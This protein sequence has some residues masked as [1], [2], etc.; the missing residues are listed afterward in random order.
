MCFILHWFFQYKSNV[1][2]ELKKEHQG[3]FNRVRRDNSGKRV[4]TED[5]GSDTDTGDG[6]RRGSSEGQEE[7]NSEK[8]VKEKK[9]A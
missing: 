3:L 1:V 4:V 5:K 6:L 7:A 9:Q 8:G 2:K